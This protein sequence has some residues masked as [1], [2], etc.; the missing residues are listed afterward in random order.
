MLAQD[1]ARRPSAHRQGVQGGLGPTARVWAPGP[2]GR[3]GR[4]AGRWP[5]R[6]RPA[7][8]AGQSGWA[9]PPGLWALRRR[10][11]KVAKGVEVWALNGGG[12][13]RAR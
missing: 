10:A 9:P 3:I 4:P 2:A 7:G 5:V 11:S 12:R 6:G 1:A 13:P 8:P